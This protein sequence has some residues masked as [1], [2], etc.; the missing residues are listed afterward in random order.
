MI[1]IRSIG[2]AR[3]SLL[4]LQLIIQHILYHSK[5]ILRPLVEFQEGL[6]HTFVRHEETLK[7]NRHIIF[8]FIY[9]NI[10]N[11]VNAAT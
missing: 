7:I 11:G 10:I 9:S 6:T 8:G 3:D 4:Y 2:C 1:F 5:E